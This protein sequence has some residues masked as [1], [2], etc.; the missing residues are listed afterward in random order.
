M[1][2]FTFMKKYLQ[3][4]TSETKMHCE[5]LITLTIELDENKYSQI[6][7]YED[8]NPEILASNF[9]T[10]NYLSMAYVE[11]LKQNIIQQMLMYDQMKKQEKDKQP[12]SQW[13]TVKKQQQNKENQQSTPTRNLNTKR[14]T[15]EKTMPT[16]L[17][18]ERNLSRNKRFQTEDMNTHDRLYQQTKQTNNIKQQK[19]EHEQISKQKDPN[20]TFKPKT[21]NIQTNNKSKSP[22]SNQNQFYLQPTQQKQVQLKSPRLNQ[23]YQN[24]SF[25]FLLPKKEVKIS[26]L[27]NEESVTQLPKTQDSPNVSFSEE[28]QFKNDSPYTSAQ[29][30]NCLYQ[31]TKDSDERIVAKLFKMIESNN[32]VDARN[33]PYEKF[34][35]QLIVELRLHFQ[36]NDFK[37]MNCEQFCQSVLRNAKLIKFATDFFKFENVQYQNTCYYH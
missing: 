31:A 27:E 32:V 25:E 3:K 2:Q 23:L 26:I 19:K 20:L 16:N 21:N 11:P 30:E 6:N 29:E 35:Y 10:D 12:L 14:H 9:V 37:I 18:S 15:P 24:K 17:K 5:P 28:S 7:I 4:Q 8:S 33:I 1:S 22:Q 36:K 34:N 13:E